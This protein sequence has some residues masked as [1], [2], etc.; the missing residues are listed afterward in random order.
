MGY[1]IEYEGAERYPLPCKRKPGILHRLC[2]AAIGVALLVTLIF[3][4][5][6]QK[7]VSL[8]IPGNDSVTLQ[9]IGELT[10]RLQCGE[11]PKEAVAAFC[12]II[13]ENGQ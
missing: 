10:E 1:C 3:P 4:E 2:L 9:A 7:L 13:I 8:L 12:R 6:K 5:T 11:H